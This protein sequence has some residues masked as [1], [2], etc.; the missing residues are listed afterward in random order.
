MIEFYEPE[1]AVEITISSRTH[2][3]RFA[4]RS[5]RL[6]LV[7]AMAALVQTLLAR[8]HFAHHTVHGQQLRMVDANR[9]AN[10]RGTARLHQLV[11]GQWTARRMAQ[12]A[13]LLAV[14]NLALFAHDGRHAWIGGAHLT[15][16]RLAFTEAIDDRLHG[17]I[18][19][20]I[21]GARLVEEDDLAAR[22]T[23]QRVNGRAAGQRGRGGE[24]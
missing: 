1:N 5:D 16:Q 11:L 9:V 4:H 6:H 14:P 17:A 23:R 3:L 24:E 22:R 7:P 12:L 2:L 18:G 19:G 20:Q 21:A 13:A 8:R 15:A 10:H